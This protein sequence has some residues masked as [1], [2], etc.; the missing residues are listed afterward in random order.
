METTRRNLPPSWALNINMYNSGIYKISNIITNDFY[1]GSSA[2]L[3]KRKIRHFCNLR[4]N[5]HINK[6]LQNSWNKY[7]ESNFKFEILIICEISLLNYYEQK[8]IDILHPQFNKRLLAES[9]R[10][11][12][13]SEE[14]RKK[15]SLS[16][17]GKSIKILMNREEL[18]KIR[19]TQNLGKKHSEETKQ[20]MSK[21][22]LGFKHSEES[23]KKMSF[24]NKG[25]HLSEETKEKISKNSASAKTYFG[26]V[27]PDGIVYNGVHNLKQ[28][29]R[30]NSLHYGCMKRLIKGTRKQHLG[31]KYIS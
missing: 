7:K 28:F 29:C 25:K 16:R 24:V 9:N 14:T 4:N 20:K 21:A 19:K 17:K 12:K 3:D 22:H 23:R 2:T 27:S 1:I 5:R 31:W 8:V 6:H 10:G 26:I 15:M 18:S 11:Y 30:E 13:L